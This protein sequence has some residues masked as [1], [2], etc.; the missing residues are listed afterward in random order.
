[1]TGSKDDEFSLDASFNG[2]PMGLFTSMLLANMPK[3]IN[4]R[5][6]VRMTYQQ[7]MTAVSAAVSKQ[8]SA[9]GWESNQ[10]PQLNS[11]LGNPRMPIFSVPA[12]RSR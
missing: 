2:V 9:P 4:P 3:T 10:N 8:A 6:P 7:L 5:K 11:D 12:A 1:M